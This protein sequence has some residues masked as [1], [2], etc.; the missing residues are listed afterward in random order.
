MNEAVSPYFIITIPEGQSPVRIVHGFGKLD[1]R[2][3]SLEKAW[4]LYQAGYNNIEITEEGKA[5][6]LSQEEAQELNDMGSYSVK[7]IV[8]QINLACCKKD[9]E[10]WLNKNPESPTVKRAYEKK[11]KTLK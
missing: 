9:C 1:L 5:K 6:F 4:E 2:T 11:L 3:I 8:Q 10:F 7:E